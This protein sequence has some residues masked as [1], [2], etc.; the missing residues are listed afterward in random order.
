MNAFK[1]GNSTM[2]IQCVIMNLIKQNRSMFEE[3]TINEAFRREI[4]KKP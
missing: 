1:S 3:K 4:G 2:I